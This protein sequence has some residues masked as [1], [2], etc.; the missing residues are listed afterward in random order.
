VLIE[1]P[2]VGGGVVASARR[3]LSLLDEVLGV[4]LWGGG[5]FLV[6]SLCSLILTET[7]SGGMPRAMGSGALLLALLV[8]Q[9]GLLWVM[10]ASRVQHGLYAAGGVLLWLGA[11]P[12]LHIGLGKDPLFP[13]PA[14][15]IAAAQ[16]VPFLIHYGN[17]GGS[18]L[19]SAILLTLGGMCLA[20]SL[21]PVAHA[22][23]AGF[24]RAWVVL[25]K[26]MRHRRLATRR[27]SHPRGGDVLLPSAVD[28]HRYWHTD[29][30]N[31]LAVSTQGGPGQRW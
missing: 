24:R 3:C 6:L 11:T 28:W 5:I 31:E 9:A 17:V 1:T 15:G 22:C 10:H 14:G 12:I 21:R 13:G 27:A 26:P 7:D 23:M 25:A 2:C 20:R 8:W 30:A 19:L 16:L 4:M 18:L 29:E